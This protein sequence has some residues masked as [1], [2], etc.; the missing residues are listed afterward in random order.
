[1]ALVIFWVFL[2]AAILRRRLCKLGIGSAQVKGQSLLLGS[3]SHFLF[4]GRDNFFES[5]A[6][7]VVNL[8][9]GCDFFLHIRMVL[10]YVV[11]QVRFKLLDFVDWDIVQVSVDA[12]VN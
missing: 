8:S 7:L 4:K 9:D 2:N 10:L 5:A 1:M 12:G 3:V 6:D 11:Q